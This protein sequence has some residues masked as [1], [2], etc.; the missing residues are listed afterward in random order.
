MKCA[1]CNKRTNWD[2]SVGRPCFLV[3]NEC[4][5]DIAKLS[6]TEPFEVTG[7]ILEMGWKIEKRKEK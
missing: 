2:H 4:V 6:D 5:E 3:C 1:I 7:I